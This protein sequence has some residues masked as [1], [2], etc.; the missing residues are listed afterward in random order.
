[1]RLVGI[2]FKKHDPHKIVGNH[3]ESCGLKRYE[4]KVSPHDEVFRGV[5]TY[6]EVLNRVR[7]LQSRDMFDFY[8]FQ[9][10]RRSGLPKVLQG[11]VSKPPGSQQAEAEGP[12]GIGP[13]EQEAQGNT[14]KTK[15]LKQE[16]EGPSHE[17][18]SP[19]ADNPDRQTEV[20]VEMPAKQVG[21][22]LLLTPNKLGTDA[23]V[24]N[25]PSEI[26]SPIPSVTPLQFS[27][28]DPDAGAISIEDLMPITAEEFPPSEFFFS[29]KRRAIVKWETHH[30]AGT[31]AKKFKILTDDKDLEEEEFTDEI[32]GMLGA[33]ATTNQYSVGTLR[34]RLKHKDRLI[35]ELQSR[36]SE[37]ETNA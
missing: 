16:S 20:R 19:G 33:Y 18:R 35:S 25:I 8:K 1:M 11:T 32:A 10:H 34:S 26:G 31:V 14:E 13:D 15:V 12:T 9:E 30:Q 22:P 28:G 17:E 5:K 24:K 6:S 23:G 27:R 4:H 36:L 3:L 7:A 2:E 21:D 29:K 37:S